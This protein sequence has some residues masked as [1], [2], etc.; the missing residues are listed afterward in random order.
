M[1]DITPYATSL[2]PWEKR[3]I[4]AAWVG[5]SHSHGLAL[6]DSDIDLRVI[7][8]PTAN[9]ILLGKADRTTALHNPDITVMTPQAFVNMLIKGAPNALEALA[10][11][12]DCILTGRDFLNGYAAHAAQLTTR[13][14]IDGAL[15]NARANIHRLNRNAGLDDRSRRKLACTT[16]RLLGTVQDVQRSGGAWSTRSDL[17]PP[18]QL[19]AVK[20]GAAPIPNLDSI[21]RQT[22]SAAQLHP[23]PQ[24]APEIR[25]QCVGML[26]ALH[27]RIVAGKP[28]GA[29]MAAVTDSLSRFGEA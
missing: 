24:L 8:A 16:L 29:G 2:K 15:G 10:L 18:E 21:Y 12:S 5:G 4:L 9:E 17:M 19:L 13:A 3:S 1:T 28:V 20:D 23:R 26:L 11:P 25:E 22:E 7:T 6:P 14:T 27:R